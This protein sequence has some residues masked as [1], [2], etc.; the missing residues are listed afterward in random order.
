MEEMEESEK[1]SDYSKLLC[2][3]NQ[4]S[5]D[6]IE[7]YLELDK[8]SKSE[9]SEIEILVEDS[10]CLPEEER[11]VC[12]TMKEEDE[13]ISNVKYEGEDEKENAHSS[14]TDLNLEM[15]KIRYQNDLLLFRLEQSEQN[16]ESL[17]REIKELQTTNK[18][19]SIENDIALKNKLKMKEEE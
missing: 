6:E 5:S 10:L 19:N 13:Y 4:M 9:D 17:K 7:K 12:K 14:R 16:E 2:N 15:C 1:T 3:T 11:D 8:L 18:K